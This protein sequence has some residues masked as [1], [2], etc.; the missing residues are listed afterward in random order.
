MRDFGFHH[1]AGSDRGESIIGLPAGR[2]EFAVDRDVARREG[3]EQGARVGEIIV[4]DRVEVVQAAVVGQIPA[5]IFGIALKD[6]GATG[7]MRADDIGARADGHT[8]RAGGEIDAVP[9]GFLQD[10][11]QADEQRQFGIRGVEGEADGAVPDLFDFATFS[12]E[13]EYLGRPFLPMSPLTKS[14]PRQ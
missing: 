10:R 3:L 1:G 11:A 14:H 2:V 9:I 5:P 13:L 7:F 12:Q 6:D 8:Q 4:A